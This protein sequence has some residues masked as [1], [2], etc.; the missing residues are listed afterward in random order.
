[1][2]R[3]YSAL[4]AC[5]AV[6]VL[7]ALAGGADSSQA[8]SPLLYPDLVS[9]P[10][11]N[12]RLEIYDDGTTE[13][14]LMRFDG[15]VHNA[16]AGALELRGTDPVDRHMTHVIQRVYRGD[17]SSADSANT[18]TPQLIFET[19]D[20]HFHWHFMHASRYSM[21]DDARAA[22]VGPA[23]KVGFCLG[24]SQRRES[25]VTTP[26][27]TANCGHGDEAAPEVAMGVSAG[28]RDYYSSFLALQWVDASDVRP[29]RYW[30]RSDVDPDGLVVESQEANEPGWA[31]NATVIPGYV[32]DGLAGGVA[33]DSPSQV[34]LPAT[35]WGTPGAAEY[36]VVDAPQHG[37]LSVPVDQPF[38][39]ATLTYTPDAGYRGADSFKYEARDATSSYPIHPS[40]ASAVLD[41]GGAH[42]AVGVSG[43]PARMYAGTSVQLHAT[44]T[45]GVSSH[46]DWSASSGAI[47]PSGLYTAPA[48]VP[49]GGSA[50][51]EARGASGTPG[52]AVIGIDPAP[53]Q[54]PAPSLPQRK[55]KRGRNVLTPIRVAHHGRHLTA[56]TKS[57]RA[58][59]LVVRARHHGRRLASC[60]FRAPRLRAL[61]CRMRLPH[62]F[63]SH[64]SR[65]LA[66][67]VRAVLRRHGRVVAIRRATVR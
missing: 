64:G 66:I 62:R 16:G 51:I 28:W 52:T 59:K 56:T 17:G 20:D 23:S 50:R 4:L 35:K 54:R 15:F 30:M 65:R 13:R 37:Q 29:G 3:R 45:G 14:L 21:W 31:A 61:T 27:Y 19:N 42:A 39:A 2:A 55:S 43:A 48:A 47:S 25:Q 7:V 32:V 10:P 24:D 33:A 6:A 22:E 49:A 53:A 26:T 34:D 44:V 46:V 67:V 63:E 40:S 5:A 11:G 36:R 60:T 18:P 12:S 41:V 38:S 9:D 58:G 8:D 57:R 1:M